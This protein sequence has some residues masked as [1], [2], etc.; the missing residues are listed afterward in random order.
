MMQS[1]GIGARATWFALPLVLALLA[2]AQEEAPAREKPKEDPYAGK[3]VKNARDGMGLIR[4][5]A[6][7]LPKVGEPAPDFML[8]TPDGKRSVQLSSFRGKRP[9]VLVFGSYT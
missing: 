3:T 2:P 1:I 6:R 5:R 7:N 8:K 4:E 9:V